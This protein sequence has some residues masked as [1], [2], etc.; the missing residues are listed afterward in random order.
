MQTTG[1]FYSQSSR[2]D[3]SQKTT[4]ERQCDRH[5]KKGLD[6]DIKILTISHSIEN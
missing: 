4:V 6:D 3:N 2:V 1:E 5:S